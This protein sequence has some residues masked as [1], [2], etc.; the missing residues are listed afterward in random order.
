MYIRM[1]VCMYI[2]MCICMYTRA[3]THTH[4]DASGVS[5]MLNVA[6]AQHEYC[7]LKSPLFLFLNSERIAQRGVGAARV[8]P[9]QKSSI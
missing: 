5:E 8:L 6:W 9:S 2:R 1:Y 7:L 4:T 3:R